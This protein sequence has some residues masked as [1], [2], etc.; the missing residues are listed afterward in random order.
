MSGLKQTKGK[1]VREK[2]TGESRKSSFCFSLHVFFCP[3]SDCEL[4]FSARLA[5]PWLA[6][7]SAVQKERFQLVLH[8]S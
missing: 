5:H 6:G 8:G 4:A 3:F 2:G 1:S 7:L